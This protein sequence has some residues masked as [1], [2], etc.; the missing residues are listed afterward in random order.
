MVS[1]TEKTGKLNLI[2][3]FVSGSLHPNKMGQHDKLAEILACLQ[4]VSTSVDALLQQLK[5]AMDKMLFL[6]DIPKTMKIKAKL[7]I[8]HQLSFKVYLPAWYKIF[9]SS[10]ESNNK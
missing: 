2:T 3:N 10:K 5:R 4:P 9:L 7:H 1:Y 8:K 6:P